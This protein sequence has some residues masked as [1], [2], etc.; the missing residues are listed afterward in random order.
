MIGITGFFLSFAGYTL[1]LIEFTPWAAAAIPLFIVSALILLLYIF[2]LAG[3]LIH[4]A[5]FLSGLG[6]ALGLTG[7]FRAGKHPKDY[8]AKFPEPGPAIFFILA[9]ILWL[10]LS[11]THYSSWDEFSHWG[12]IAKEIFLRNAL[13][14]LE[15]AL[16]FKD[17]PPATA[18]FQYYVVFFTGWSEGAT[19]FAQSLILLSAA[20]A[21]LHGSSWKQGLKPA[22]IISLSYLLLILFNYKPQSLYVDHVL[23]FLFGASIASCLLSDTGDSWAIVRIIPTLLILPIVKAAGLLLALT[24]AVAIAT[25]H[26][27]GLSAATRRENGKRQLW[28][29]IALCIVILLSPLLTAK[30]WNQR[31]KELGLAKT[32]ET[33]IAL[34]DIKKSFSAAASK[35]DTTTISIFKKALIGNQVGR[36]LPPV[37]LILILALAA[38]AAAGKERRGTENLQIRAVFLWI[39]AGFVVYASGLL[40]LYLYSFSNYEGPRLASFGRY[41]GV[42][43]IGWSLVTASFFLRLPPPAGPARFMRYAKPLIILAAAAALASALFKKDSAEKAR[44]HKD[45]REKAEYALSKTPADSRIYIVWQASDGFEPQVMAYELAPRITS[46][47]GGGWSLGKPYYPGDVWTTDVPAKDWQGILKN[48]D[49][50]MLGNADK[51]FWERFSRLFENPEKVRDEYLFK[52]TIKNSGLK[53]RSVSPVL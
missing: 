39:L 31:V 21:L 7:L 16:R 33:K 12:F 51:V 22:A 6:F 23:G 42:F 30:S 20:T 15:S 10:L 41:M 25:N 49:F 17:Y 19:A 45:I 52:V 3:L 14:P 43:F 26:L 40:M 24:A 8:F 47:R 32:F 38:F 4:G 44:L 29:S 18:L 11:G 37:F 9:V 13:P 27:I 34:T 50:V 36:S 53:L 46:T 5:Y 28:P 2:S 1:F 48:Y 35:R